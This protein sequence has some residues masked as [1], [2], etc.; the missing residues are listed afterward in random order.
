MNVSIRRWSLAGTQSSAL[1]LPEAVSPIGTWPAIRDGRSETSKDWIALM[2]DSP[3]ISRP[4][5]LSSPRPSGVTKP[6]PVTTTRLI[7]F[8]VQPFYGMYGL[9]GRR[10][11]SSR[12]SV[13][14]GASAMRLDKAHRVLDGDDLLG[15][16]IG[17]FAPE[18]FLERHDQLDRVEA[19][20]TQ[21]VDKAGVLSHLGIVD[22]KVLDDDLLD[23]LGDVAHP[24]SSSVCWLSSRF[25]ADP[26]ARMWAG[27]WAS[28]HGGRIDGAG[29]ITRFNRVCQRAQTIAMPPLTCSVWPVI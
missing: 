22:A 24:F 11:R 6:I 1:Y 4:H 13:A 21:I 9:P 17:D 23:P 3:A 26:S 18:F 2:P 7:A 29:H 10:L 12:P 28:G 25:D 19:V 5:T 14:P 16:V 20:G 15:R 27:S 8:P